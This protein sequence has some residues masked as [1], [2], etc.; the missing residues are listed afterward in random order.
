MRFWSGGWVVA[1]LLDFRS[2]DH[3]SSG[4]MDKAPTGAPALAALTAPERI[5]LFCVASGTVPPKTGKIRRTIEGLTTKG[6]IK[7]EPDG[8]ALTALGRS[9]LEALLSIS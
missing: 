7:R 1:R 5:L 9:T 4:T 3:R 8:L 6:L 2:R